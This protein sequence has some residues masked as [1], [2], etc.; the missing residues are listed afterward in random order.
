MK[1]GTKFS[2]LFKGINWDSKFNLLIQVLLVIFA[3]G[4]LKEAQKSTKTAQESSKATQDA[5]AL[6]QQQYE[7]AKKQEV[8]QNLDETE[9]RKKDIELIE[10]QIAALKEQASAINSG[11]S[12]TKQIQKPVL[13][14]SSIG[15]HFQDNKDV[16]EG[17]Y[18]IL[19]FGLTPATLETVFTYT[20]DSKFNLVGKDTA[21]ANTQLIANKFFQNNFGLPLVD[22]NPMNKTNVSKVTTFYVCI[23]PN[24]TNEI[25]K[26]KKSGNP[27]IYRWMQKDEYQIIRFNDQTIYYLNLCNQKELEILHK[28]LKNI[29]KL[30]LKTTWNESNE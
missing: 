11:V 3:Y 15:L 19:N 4:A 10:Q 22:G 27:L 30:K 26:S 5:L 13:D 14:I 20:F 18:I 16:L 23:I 2:N 6:Q 24:Y 8:Q 29:D 1:K 25:T 21:L 7:D 9:K 28:K 17:K 12:N